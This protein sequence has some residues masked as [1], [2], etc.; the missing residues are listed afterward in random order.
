MASGVKNKQKQSTRV[1]V[2]L[3]QHLTSAYLCFPFFC[4]SSPP[5]IDYEFCHN[6]V[7]VASYFEN[8][9]TWPINLI[10]TFQKHQG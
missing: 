9:K 6:I 7:K 8:V 3:F 2:V 5:P 1:L 4:L 10:S